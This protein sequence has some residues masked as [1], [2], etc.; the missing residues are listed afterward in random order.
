MEKPGQ[1]H[2]DL[3]RRRIIARGAPAAF[4]NPSP[5]VGGVEYGG[6]RHCVMQPS[7]GCNDS[8]AGAGG[9]GATAAP[10]PAADRNSC[11]KENYSSSLSPLSSSS[12]AAV[13]CSVLFWKVLAVTTPQLLFASESHGVHSLWGD[14]FATA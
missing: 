5:A 6:L 14:N 7:R 3:K 2:S 12:L 13:A 9:A 10:A 4:V 1:Q 11:R 8:K